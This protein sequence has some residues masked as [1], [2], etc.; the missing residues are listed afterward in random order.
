MLGLAITFGVG[1]L[2]FV[3]MLDGP[4]FYTAN[5]LLSHRFMALLPAL[6]VGFYLLYVQ[7]TGWRWVARRSGRI[8]V[9]ALAFLCFAVRGVELVAQPPAVGGPEHV[10][11][12]YVD[13]AALPGVLDVLPRLLVFAGLAMQSAAAFVL[14]QT[15]RAGDARTTVR[16]GRVGIAGA[17]LTPASLV[18]HGTVPGMA[19]ATAPF[20]SLL[21]VEALVVVGWAVRRRTPLVAMVLCVGTLLAF[22]RVA[23]LRELV[24]SAR[25]A[26]R[27]GSADYRT[28]D[29]LPE[30]FLTLLLVVLAIVWCVLRVRRDLRAGQPA[31]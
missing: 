10:A 13:D 21:V 20:V 14:L 8:G 24:W 11:A 28:I 12:A 4:A 1:P 29:G 22:E 17:I 9:P 7:K 23:W 3:Q 30:F 27:P 18:W 6:I 5:L 26:G 15:W 16:L 19:D 2:L 31:P 25:T